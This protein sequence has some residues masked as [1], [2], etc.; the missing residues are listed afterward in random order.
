MQAYAHAASATREEVLTLRDCGMLVE[1]AVSGRKYYTLTD[2][3][4]WQVFQTIGAVVR[5]QSSALPQESDGRTDNAPS[6]IG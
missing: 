4:W 1:T 6:P 2:S 3:E 5:A